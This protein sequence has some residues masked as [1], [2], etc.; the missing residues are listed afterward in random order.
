MCFA[1]VRRG[2]G[3]SFHTP[4]VCSVAQVHSKV[5]VCS[6]QILHQT[7]N[8]NCYYYRGKKNILERKKKSL[9]LSLDKRTG[10]IRGRVTQARTQRSRQRSALAAAP[11]YKLRMARDCSD[12]K[13]QSR[14]NACMYRRTVRCRSRTLPETRPVR[15][16]TDACGRPWP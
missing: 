13:L 9:S 1:P 8:N 14:L 3:W 6:H 15:A 7:N 4:F 16:C 11:C 2:H 10:Y 12:S 5:M